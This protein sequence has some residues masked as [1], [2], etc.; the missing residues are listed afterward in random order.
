MR[1]LTADGGNVAIIVALMMTVLM[2]VAALAVDVGAML[3]QN[4][5][6]QAGT[7][8]AALAVARDCAEQATGLAPVPCTFAQAQSTANAYLADTPDVAAVT[9][10]L[11]TALGGKAGMVTVAGASTQPGMFSSF[12]G[13]EDQ[14]TSARA[15][16]RWGPLLAADAVFP[17]A[18]CRGALPE[19]DQ[20]ITLIV[21]P[22]DAAPPDNCTGLGGDDVVPLGWYDADDPDA[23]TR[24]VVL[25][26]PDLLTSRP[27]QD[28]PTTTGCVTAIDEL[29]TAIAT[30]APA[31][32]RRRVLAVSDRQ[33]GGPSAGPAHAL[34]AFE[35]DGLR[36]G[37][38]EEHLGD[39]WTADSGC[40]VDTVYC[41]RGHV[42]NWVPPAEGP[43]AD[44]ALIGLPS[45]DDTT[46]LHVRLV[47]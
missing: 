39:P 28:L 46:V 44:P 13:I 26:P 36:L 33:Y 43:I 16:A 20:P 1:R 7:D 19:I 41:I 4:A 5:R 32:D 38:R 40:D 12:L 27:V 18:V 35:F 25:V 30:G 37:P 31:E 47:E 15:S 10:T 42:R 6:L 3:N 9:P 34:I 17:M 23:C 24:S 8:A 14:Q 22:D 21:D 29:F 11:S 45:I 2:G